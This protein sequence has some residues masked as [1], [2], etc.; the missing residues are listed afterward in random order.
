MKRR[1]ERITENLD[2]FDFALTEADMAAITSPGTG[3]S[4][5]VDHRDPHQVH[6]LGAWTP[7]V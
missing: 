1:P 7:S 5:F 4:L 2:V 6:G 3:T